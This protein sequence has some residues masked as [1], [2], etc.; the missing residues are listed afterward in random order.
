M[1]TLFLRNPRLTLLTIGL[2]TVAGLSSY[3]VLPRM[4]DPLLTERAA[5]IF[6]SLPGADADQVESLV[7]DPI[8]DELRDIAEIKEVRSSSRSSFST[9]TV[10][11]RDEVYSDAAPAIWSR[12][13]DRIA[14]AEAELPENAS[15][16]RFERIEVTAY[17]RLIA[18]AWDDAEA[19]LD[20]PLPPG[21]HAILRRQAEDLRERLL[22]V[23]GTKDVDIFGA[24]DEEITVAADPQKLT[25]LGLTAL[26][27]SRLI[28][29]SDS[30]F[31]AGFL[32]GSDTDLLIELTGEL[33][34]LERISAIPIRT[35]T[36]GQL[37]T[38][39]DIAEVR[40][41]VVN[42]PTDLA[43]VDGKR[44]IVLACLIRPSQR[45]DWWSSASEAV[46][47][48]FE[49]ELPRGIRMIEVFSQDGY[50]TERLT[51]LLRNLMIGA[52]SVM[53]VILFLMGWRSA[54]I[55]GAA[56]P[57]SA[58]MVL[59]GMRLLHIPVHQMSVTGLIIALGLLIDNAI[60]VVDEVGQKLRAGESAL[61]AVGRTVH[62]LAVPLF[63]S[64]FTTA[65]AF[66]PIALM[67]GPAGEFVG[68][69]AV[70]VIVAIFSSLLLAMTVVPTLTGF[71]GAQRTAAVES[72]SPQHVADGP[73]RTSWFRDG[74]RNAWLGRRYESLL[75]LVTTR[76]VVGIL[77]GIA[78]PTVG[79]I[80]ARLLPEQFFPPADRDQIAIELDFSTQTSLAETLNQATR[81]RNIL[82]QRDDVQ[83][84]TWWIGRSAPP[85]Y[86]NQ[87]PSRRG[88]SQYA[89]ALVKLDSAADLPNRINNMQRDMDAL[90]PQ[91][92]VLVRQLEQGPPFEAPIEVQVFGPNLDRLRDISDEING[93]LAS[94][95]EVTH[96]RAETSEPQPR[97]T[98]NVDEEEARLAGLTHQDVA[99]QMYTSLEGAVGGLVLEG[100][101]VLPVRV[102][103][104]DANR[105][106]V[107]NIEGLDV[108]PARSDY[109]T[110][111]A[112]IPLTSLG[113]IELSS[114]QAAITHE[115]R[116]RMTEVQA[117]LK[118]GELPAPIQIEFQR[119]LKESGFTLPPGYELEFGG[120]SAQRDNAIGNLM[121]SV[122]VLAVMMVAALVLSFGSFRLAAL[123]GVVAFLAV[124]LGLGALWVFG[125]PFG[126]MAIIGTMGLVGVAINDSIVVLAAIRGDEAARNGDLAA[127]RAVVIRATRHVVA[128]SLTTIAGFLPL[129]L[130]G[131]GFWP[132][133]AVTI[134]G[135]V[136]GATVL[137]LIFV[138]ACYLIAMKRS[139]ECS[140]VTAAAA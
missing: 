10:E 1:S 36:T 19:Q 121:A 44:A 120:E 124:G 114:T 5:F 24:P 13:R 73:H 4:E 41:D 64:T 72:L 94:I 128:T 57:L 100:T 6:T 54:L 133:M 35:T 110:G 69:I 11:L 106:S 122:G 67:P 2:I 103:V 126:F 89:Q 62:H 88:Q 123:V 15:K 25:S 33:D 68:A 76:P 85:F 56:L 130:G 82:L 60:V 7:T 109:S 70:N 29:A 3:L 98:V 138:P 22:G 117:F 16:P 32:R 78:L 118:A 129:I 108:L 104:G 136:G 125:F 31:S 23:P 84:V 66:A 55:V 53:L 111:Y 107:D 39:G 58:F 21:M 51:D 97:L 87:I 59:T 115:D 18:L 134:A 81:M 28:T 95:P 105:S 52:V 42:P 132:P 48:E 49:R 20:S 26:D 75:R 90:F 83:D 71:L 63:G 112:G 34:S 8:E 12:I 135:G 14:D 27:I 38:V 46:T 116:R 93:V 99:T 119:R 9:I 137:A 61:D 101:E 86:Y 45:I 91:A 50:V 92:R 17:T 79:F 77:I 65:L 131:G 43:I 40:R 102:R 74:W 47:T 113:T 139:F 140:T 37:V 96:V 80:Q 127:I 30:R